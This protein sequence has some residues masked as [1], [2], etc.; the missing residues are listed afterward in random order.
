MIKNLLFSC[1]LFTAVTISAKTNK[2]ALPEVFYKCWMASY[3]DDDQKTM[4]RH[5]RSCDY[6]EFKP[7]RYRQSITF[8]KNGV[9]KYLQLSPTDAHF[10]VEGKWSYNHKTK[11]IS[12]SDDKGAPVFKFRIK[13]V[14][15]SVMTVEFDE[16]K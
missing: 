15:K 4:V 14:D 13:S 11:L 9:C 2:S 16:K 8:E 3:E 12:V 10:I 6:K 5:Y 1:L 7:T